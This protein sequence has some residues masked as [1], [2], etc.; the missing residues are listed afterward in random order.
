[1]YSRQVVTSIFLCELENR[2]E[3]IYAF[4]LPAHIS[5]DDWIALI[6]TSLL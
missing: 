3:K 6:L 1:M 4:V 2:E 5:S